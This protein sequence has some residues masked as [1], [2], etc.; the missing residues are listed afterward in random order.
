MENRSGVLGAD[1]QNRQKRG[2][3]LLRLWRYLGRNRLLLAAAVGLSLGSNILALFGPR[4][5]GQAINAIAA[6]GLPAANRFI[7]E[8][9]G[10]V[11]AA[12][13]VGTVG[14]A[15]DAQILTMKVFGKMGGAYDSDYMAAIEDAIILGCDAVNLSLGSS[16]AGFTTSEDYE[17]LLDYLTE[18]DCVVA[19]ASGN[20]GYWTAN[21]AGPMPNLYVEDVNFQTAGS[22]ST[23]TNSFAFSIAAS[24]NE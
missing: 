20:S 3:L 14:N 23:Y 7:K 12:D 4:L 21:A 9:S 11:S 5:A 18:T 2:A 22:P 6:P 17:D 1:R 13:A 8:G 24:T 16:S 19:M 15:P 10:Y